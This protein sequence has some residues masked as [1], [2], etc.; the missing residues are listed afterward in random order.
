MS[1]T[2]HE[3]ARQIMIRVAAIGHGDIAQRR[4]FPE[5]K[6]LGGRAELVAVAGRDPGRLV[7]TATAFGV[8]RMTTIDVHPAQACM[9]IWN[10]N[11]RVTTQCTCV[12][13]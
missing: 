11:A 7:A 6:Q 2:L 13:G 3:E 12:D 9:P 1:N 4:H 10:I 8:P 5:L